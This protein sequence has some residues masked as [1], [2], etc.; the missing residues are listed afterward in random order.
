LAWNATPDYGS[1]LS[2]IHKKITILVDAYNIRY[3]LFIQLKNL[4]CTMY[5]GFIYKSYKLFGVEESQMSPNT[6]WKTLQD[7]VF[8]RPWGNCFKN[9]MFVYTK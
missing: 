7:L 9:D 8:K 6:E 5:T 2:W 3:L 4:L 1:G